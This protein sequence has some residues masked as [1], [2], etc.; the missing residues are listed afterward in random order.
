VRDLLAVA[1]GG[2]LGTLLRWGGLTLA[3]PLARTFPWVTLAENVAGAFLL[4]WVTGA[5]IRRR[6]DAHILHLFLGPG[7]LGSFTTFSALALDAVVLG[8]EAGALYLTLSVGGG[9]AAA[10]AGLGLGRSSR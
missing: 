1:A 2:A 8:P 9:I 3:A 7:L 6:P 5:V 4:G 10:G